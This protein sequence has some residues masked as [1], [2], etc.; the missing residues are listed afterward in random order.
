M[1]KKIYI[2]T[3]NHKSILGI[4]THITILKKILKPYKVITT[5][6]IKK[7]SI[8]IFIENFKKKDVNKINYYKKKF[9][10]TIILVLTE[11]VNSNAK[12][13]NCFELKKRINKLIP[14]QYFSLLNLIILASIIYT[15]F[16]IFIK[17]Y[18]TNIKNFYP[19]I[20][21]YIF[22]FIRQFYLFMRL[23]LR[24]YILKNTSFNLRKYRKIR[25]KFFGAPKRKKLI[26][27]QMKWYSKFVIYRYFRERFIN[28]EKVVKN[29]DIILTTHPQIYRSYKVYKKPIFYMFPKIKKFLPNINSN[30][31]L[32]FKFSGELSNY[33][34]KVFKKIIDN[35]NNTGNQISKKNIYNFEQF[36]LNYKEGS[37][38]DISK[39][40]KFKYSFHPR[41]NIIWKYSSPIRYIEAISNGEVPIIFDNFKDFF[42]KNL[43]VKFK[44]N[45]TQNI[46]QFSLRYIYFISLLKR[47][48]KKY[49]QFTEKNLYKL[50][51]TISSIR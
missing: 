39:K 22:Y 20:L 8:N 35:Y 15:I 17:G 29:A 43:T 38:V 5:N 33:R 50:K 48:I 1:S 18:E 4:K 24:N 45:S 42:A 6:K 51:L 12:I 26:I 25:N 30:E 19:I 40:R 21:V 46:N 14:Y 36:L 11:F 7:N 44:Q 37:F 49:N 2:Y 9:N 27:T 3:N 13:F 10:I 28:N 23:K 41:K 16:A 32:L 47:G 31:K 34:I